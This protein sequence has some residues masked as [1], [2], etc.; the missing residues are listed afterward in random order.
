M[1]VDRDNRMCR[2]ER[3][4]GLGT[5]YVMSPYLHHVTFVGDRKLELNLEHPR[6][7]IGS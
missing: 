4:E 3:V 5:R 6:S 1:V 7:V 2:C